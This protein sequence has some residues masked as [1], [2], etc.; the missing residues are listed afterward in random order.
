MPDAV[1]IV[2]VR[3]APLPPKVMLPF[4]TNVVLDEVALSVRLPAA[5]STSLMVSLLWPLKSARH[6]PPAVTAIVGA[7]LTA[8]TVMLT[9]ASFR[10]A[11]PS[12]AL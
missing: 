10:S 7:S 8:F 5:V 3:F 6:A 9:V 12:F 2:T 1:A 11:V 4:G